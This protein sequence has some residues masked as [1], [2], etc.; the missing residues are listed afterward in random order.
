MSIGDEIQIKGRSD[1]AE[2][3]VTLRFLDYTN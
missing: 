3:E 2:R 1:K